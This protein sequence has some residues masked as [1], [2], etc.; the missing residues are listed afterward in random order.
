MKKRLMLIALAFLLII[1][2]LLYLQ[3]AKEPIVN[4]N[5]SEKAN[6]LEEKKLTEE[7]KKK[8]I[9]H[10]HKGEELI[11]SPMGDS[12]AEGYYATE[13]NKRYVEVLS[14]LIEEKLGYDVQLKSGAVKRGTGLKDTAIPNLD[15]VV[16]EQPNFITIEFGTNDLKQKKKNAYSNP[17]D[18]KKRLTYVIDYLN[19]HLSNKP[20]IIL[21]TTWA[22][23]NSLAYDAI[24]EE[25]GQEKNLPVV[26][27]ES[28]WQ[29]RIDTRGTKGV[30]T[31]L[32][33][34]DD[35]H[36]NDKGHKEIANAI[37]QKAYEVLQ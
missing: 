12:L 10:S 36:P 25:V 20:K 15:K 33:V 27:I 11:Y 1:G 5:I 26:N 28:V 16:S 18:F 19:D 7:E 30:Q 4:S 24:I 6:G 9:Y 32:G 34:S 21:V 2:M 23:E 22:R 8:Q 17:E 35:W 37:F 14:Q 13:H 31:Y 3:H 29:N